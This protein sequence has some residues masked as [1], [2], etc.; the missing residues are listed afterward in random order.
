MDRSSG[1]F[2]AERPVDGQLQARRAANAGSTTLTADG[3][4]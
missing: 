2:A 4:G 3:G 1:G